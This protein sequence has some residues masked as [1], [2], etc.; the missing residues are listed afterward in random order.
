MRL[1]VEARMGT[2]LDPFPVVAGA[3][4]SAG[5]RHRAGG[6][7]AF[8]SVFRTA[9]RDAAP[10]RPQAEPPRSFLAPVLAPFLAPFLAPGPCPVR[11]EA[12]P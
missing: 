1:Y 4:V 9:P 7:R 10:E 5:E 8:A 6:D 2:D 12:R 3:G 11:E